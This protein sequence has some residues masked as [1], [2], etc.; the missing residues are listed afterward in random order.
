M[1]KF[2]LVVMFLL[3]TSTAQAGGNFTGNQLNEYC[4]DNLGGF[5]SGLCLG[6]LRGFIE[7]H[8]YFQAIGP[9]MTVD[10]VTK[11]MGRTCMPE[12]V[13]LRQVRAV[14]LKEFRANPENL[15]MTAWVLFYRAMFKYFPCGESY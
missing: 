4:Q 15:H 14:I 7:Y 12:K 5:K 3:I 9:S 6:Y 1:K 13:T 10:G 11:L 8:Q 2:I